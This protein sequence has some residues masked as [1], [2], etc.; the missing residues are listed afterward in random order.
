MSLASAAK[1]ANPARSS[2]VWLPNAAGGLASRTAS[3]INW[4][5]TGG[6]FWSR[7]TLAP[8]A[9]QRRVDNFPNLP[10]CQNL[11]WS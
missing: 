3:H 2:A 10:C 8:T 9:V 7:M 11:N 1:P 6:A 5:R 4:L